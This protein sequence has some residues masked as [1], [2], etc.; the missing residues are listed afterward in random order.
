MKTRCEHVVD[1]CASD[2]GVFVSGSLNIGRLRHRYAPRVESPRR[3]RYHAY[4]VRCSKMT[5]ITPWLFSS[6]KRQRPR[7][8]PTSTIL[9]CYVVV[10]LII[11]FFVP[12][13]KPRR[14]VQYTSRPR[15]KSRT[16]TRSFPRVS[17]RVSTS[18]IRIDFRPRVRRYTAIVYKETPLQPDRATWPVSLGLFTARWCRHFVRCLYTR[19]C[20][21]RH[22]PPLLLRSRHNVVIR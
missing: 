12:S 17:Y 20:L 10:V 21:R 9:H 18:N 14:S 22:I 8:L 4:T 16:R 19:L 15:V 1:P 6:R 7:A 3:S 11:V 13:L 5:A 2:V